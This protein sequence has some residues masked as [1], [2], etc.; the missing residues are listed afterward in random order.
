M[1]GGVAIISTRLTKWSTATQSLDRLKPWFIL[2]SIVSE[3]II[4]DDVS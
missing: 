2:S 4:E 3:E 1:I